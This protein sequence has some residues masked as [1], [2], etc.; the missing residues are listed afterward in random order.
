MSNER[1]WNL[2][3]S[4]ANSEIERACRSASRGLTDNTMCVE[5]MVEWVEDRLMRMER[6]QGWP[7]F[8]GGPSPEEAVERVA[9]GAKLFARWAYM[10]LSR[11]HW[12]RQ[13]SSV[14]SEAALERAVTLSAVQRGDIKI[15][16]DES[17]R[18]DLAALK[19]SIDHTTLAR[20]AATWPEKSEAK[21]VAV[22]LG[23]VRKDDE[24]LIEDVLE[25]NI[26]TNTVDQMRS[27]ARTKVRAVMSGKIDSLR[28]MY[29]VAMRAAAPVI[30]VA[31]TLLGAQPAFAGEQT[32]GGRNGG[33]AMGADP[34][35]AL[36]QDVTPDG[37]QHGPMLIARGGGEQT[38]GGRGG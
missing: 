3:Y 22:A 14:S 32:G 17:L 2:Y 1:F 35:S 29:G 16:L 30:A 37:Q 23:V 6:E 10:A 15:E 8:E 7:V 36:D 20:L 4:G 34:L 13:A 28:G 5:D 38:G 24:R 12:R 25:G 11:R 31:L 21:R 9:H 19:E 26:K 27:R 33:I 18:N